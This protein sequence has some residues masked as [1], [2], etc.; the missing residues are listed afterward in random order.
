MYD[1]ILVNVDKTVKYVNSEAIDRFSGRLKGVDK[2]ICSED[3][4]NSKTTT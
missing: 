3:Q 2:I 1:S 4:H